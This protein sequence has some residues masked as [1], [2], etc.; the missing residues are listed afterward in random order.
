M[1]KRIIY[2]TLI[3]G[4]ALFITL[5]TSANAAPAVAV[6]HPA[7]DF[8]LTDVNGQ[9]HSLKDYRGKIVALG[10]I[11]TQCPVSNDYNERMRVIAE[12]YGKKNVVFLGINANFNESPAEIK[13]HA[14]KHNLTFTILKDEGNSVADAY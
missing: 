5:K 12:S 8:T 1:R 4:L 9:S 2:I 6:G 13:A 10:F 14:A 7:P 11:S 3:V